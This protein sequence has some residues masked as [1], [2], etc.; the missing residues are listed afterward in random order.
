MVKSFV[1][2]IFPRSP[3]LISVWKAYDRGEVGRRELNLIYR[4]HIKNIVNLYVEK[5]L[6][7]VHDPQSN[8]HDHFRPFT[9]FEGIELGPLTRYYENNTFFKRP[10]FN[11][12]PKFSEEILNDYLSR[13]IDER[14]NGISIPGPHMWITHSIF[15]GVDGVKFITMML[16]DIIKYLIDIG[17]RWIFL[18]EPSV[19]YYKPEGNIVE[20]LY[21]RL[22]IYRPNLVIYTYFGGVGDAL[23]RLGEMGFRYSIDM[24]WNRLE[25]IE[26]G[27]SPPI[28]GIIDGLNTFMEDPSKISEAIYKKF[29]DVDIWI[30]NNVDL[31]Y[32]PYEYAL[33]KVEV[34][35][36][37]GG[38]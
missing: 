17:Y 16:L 26:Y 19:V 10:I 25:N 2:G 14:V 15:K 30:S 11:D 33:K 4:E 5:N 32:L 38:G 36:W 34:I 22:K 35:S 28:L 23:K 29:G 21:E 6:F 3:K 37:V 18:H 13:D 24:R 20:K 7:L 1:V 8:W 12:I 31:D 9:I 27:E